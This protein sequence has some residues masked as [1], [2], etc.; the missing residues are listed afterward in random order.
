ML[1]ILYVHRVRI[2]KWPLHVAA[3]G[4][5]FAIKSV[6]SKGLHALVST[7]L[8]RQFVENDLTNKGMGSRKKGKGKAKATKVIGNDD[9]NGDD[10]DDDDDSDDGD[11]NGDDDNGDNKNMAHPPKMEFEKW[12]EGLMS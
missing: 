7:Y 8:C 3:P 4:P 12:N 1:N 2:C 9:G 11:D 5:G 6:S 10:D